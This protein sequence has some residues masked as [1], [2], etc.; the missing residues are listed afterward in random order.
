MTEG[1]FCHVFYQHFLNVCEHG[2]SENKLKCHSSSV[3]H[4]VVCTLK[5]GL[6][7]ACNSAKHDLSHLCLPG[8]VIAGRC[9]YA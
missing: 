9:H 2:G 3:L 4:C 1:S 5:Q 8:A 6:L 7:L